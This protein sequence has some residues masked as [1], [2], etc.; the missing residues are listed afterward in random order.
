MDAPERHHSG[1]DEQA[2]YISR[3]QKGT[4]R[5]TRGAKHQLRVDRAVS[6]VCKTRLTDLC[7]ACIDYKKS[8]NTASDMDPEMP[9]T[10]QI[11]Q[12]PNFW[13]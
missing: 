13:I 1:Y 8:C 11:Q 3:A 7:T 4:G 6:R 12:D 5:N 10:V 2:Q 9:K